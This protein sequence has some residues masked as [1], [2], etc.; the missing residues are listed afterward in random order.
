MNEHENL[1][2]EGIKSINHFVPFDEHMPIMFT[3]FDLAVPDFL[4]E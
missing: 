2:I 1:T 4:L 3:L